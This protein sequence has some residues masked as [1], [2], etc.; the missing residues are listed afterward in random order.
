MTSPRSTTRIRPDVACWESNQAFVCLEN[1]VSKRLDSSVDRSGVPAALGGASSSSQGPPSSVQATFFS[2]GQ[3][4]SRP[5]G[6]FASSQESGGGGYLSFSGFLWPH[7]LRPQKIRGVQASSRP[8]GLEPL[9]AKDQVSYGDSFFHP[10]L[11]TPKRLGHFLGPEGCVF[12]H[13]HPSASS[14]VAQICLGQQDLPVSGSPFRSLARPLGIHPNHQGGVCRG[15]QERHTS[16]GIPRRLACLGSHSG[17]QSPSLRRSDADC[18]ES[19][20][21]YQP[22][23]VFTRPLPDIRVPGNEIRHSFHDCPSISREARPFSFSPL[24]SSQPEGNLSSLPSLPPGTNGIPGSISPIRSGPQEGASA[25]IP[26]PMVSVQSGM[27]C[28]YFSGGLASA[29]HSPV[30]S[31]L[32]ARGRGSNILS[33]GPSRSLYGRFPSRLGRTRRGPHGLRSVASTCA[34]APHQCLGNACRS[35]RC[36]SFCSGPTTEVCSPVD[37]QHNCCM[38][39]KQRGG[40]SF[41]NP[42]SQG[43][44]PPAVLQGQGDCSKSKACLRKDQHPGRFSESSRYDPSDRMDPLPFSPQRSMVSLVQ[45]DDR[46][47]RYPVQSETTAVCLPGARSSSSGNRCT[48]NEL[49]GSLRLRFS[50]PAHSGQSN[51]EGKSRTPSPHS[52]SP[53]LASPALVPRASRAVSSSSTQTKC[54]KRRIISAKVK[55]PSRRPCKVVSSRLASVRQNLLT[56]GASRHVLDLVSKSHRSGTNAVYSSHWKRWLHWCTSYSIS[57]SDPSEVDLANF[58]AYLSQEHNLSPSSLRVYRA[59][60]STTL[61]Q[62][63]APSFSDNALL[64]DVIRGASM[65]KAQV[66]RR[67]PSWDLFLVLSSLR[68]SPYEP[69]DLADLKD[70]T[71][72][73]VFLIA[74]ASGRRA[75]EICHLSGL[76]R[77]VAREQDGSFSLRFLPEFVAKN[78]APSDPSPVIRILPLT[79]V[80][81]LDRKLCPVRSLKHYVS[82]TRE[83]RKAQRKLF[84][85]YNPSYPKDIT[86]AS[87]SRWLRCTI[88]NAY[89]HMS[90]DVVSTR[91]HEVRAWASSAAFAHSWSLKDVMAAAY[92][93]S[94]SS[95]INH[96]LRDIS[97]TRGDGSNGIST[98]V[99]AQQVVRTRP[100]N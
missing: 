88:K 1:S 3:T 77:D 13:T 33:R 26:C 67:L 86:S 11:H 27:G 51:Q 89:E 84:I 30:D 59:A 18:S 87:I 23:E 39:P 78:Q 80:D 46:P 97:L 29:S 57:P 62:L 7:L 83:I 79:D 71:L 73:T 34:R 95:F 17:A 50:S 64:R 31:G 53:S 69:L 70:L 10:I 43:G 68:E 8:L 48:V 5:G 85:S 81:D 12:P 52:G 28:P 100:S 42:V 20:F 92:W 75:S 94:E 44:V 49:G 60:I 32:V 19:R 90:L 38:L 22:D 45:T 25:P 37:R 66:P 16:S 35:P 40:M 24:S 61:R 47:I 76:S 2:R 96:Y 36:G 6:G 55:N 63:G 99:A 91:A 56:L 72:K 4:G 41:P 54:R 74:L 98:F 9:S 82:S 65:A 93:R 21:H 14:E 58:L 15:P